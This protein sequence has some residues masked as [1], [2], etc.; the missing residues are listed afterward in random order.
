MT[1][2]DPNPGFGN[3]LHQPD[4][5]KNQKESLDYLNKLIYSQ[6]SV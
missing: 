2:S 4:R 3:T 6:T 1:S 5:K